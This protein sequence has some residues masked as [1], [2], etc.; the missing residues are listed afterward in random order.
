MSKSDKKN[1]KGTKRLGTTFGDTLRTMFFGSRATKLS[2]LEEEQV[3]SPGRTMFRNFARKKTAVL[4]ATLFI[5]IL[6]ICII[7]PIFIPLDVEFQDPSQ[8]NQPPGL[9]M[10]SVPDKLKNNARSIEVGAYFSAGIDNNGSLYLWGNLTPKLREIPR[11]MGKIKQLSCGLDHIVALNEENQVFVWGYDRLKVSDVPDTV[12]EANI[13]QVVAGYQISAAIDD[14]GNLYTWGNE[15]IISISPRAVQGNV[16][17]VVLNPNT[18]LA[19][20]KDKQVVSLATVTLDINNIP[21]EVQGRVIDIAATDKAGAAVTED[22]YVHVWGPADY[23]IKDIPEDVQGHAVE[24]A[25]GRGHFTARLDD[26]TVRSWGWDIYGQTDMPGGIANAQSISADYYQNYVIDQN[27]KVTSWGLKGYLWGS[28]QF[29]RDVFTR[30]LTGGRITLTIGAIAVIISAVIGII[31]GGISGYFGGTVD[32]L[33]MRFSEIVSAIPFL[34]LALIFSALVGSKVP[35]TWRIAVIMVVL[36]LLSWPSLMRL[37]RGQIL[38]ERE[39]EFVTAAKALGV[40]ELKIIFRHIMPNVIAVALVSLTLS[41]AS[42]MLQEAVLSYLGFGVSEPNATWG[43]MLNGCN[44]STIMA[45]YWWRWVFPAA[46]LSL[47]T[48]GIN[49]TG[50]GL[51]DAIDPKSEDR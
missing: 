31:L 20:T 43:N 46:A 16:D 29:G 30:M 19:L 47:A 34:P 23:G 40:P 41:F 7:A 8:Q 14:Q 36:G 25:A 33:L 13:V 51:R 49:M 38:A 26:G 18:G 15:S 1:N 39:K 22:G 50:D 17:K 24:I 3:Q 48:V 5:G 32:L 42:C 28:D 12:Q 35:E 6:L 21:E 2:V 37:V 4:G 10:L 27:G 44:N 45:N 11:G 9:S